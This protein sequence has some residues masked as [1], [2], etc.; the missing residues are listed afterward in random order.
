MSASGAYY[1]ENDPKAAAWLRELI[2][3]G[4]IAQ[5]EV[6]DRDIRDV[7]PADL[8]GF[9]QHHFFAG[10]GIWSYALRL[11]GWPD[12]RPVW[13]GSCPC[14]P[15]SAAG[16]G[17]GFADERHLWP[18]WHWLIQQC[19]P[20]VIFGEQVEGRDGLTWLDLVSTDLEA[21]GYACGP[22]VLPAAGVG[23]PHA[24]HRLW[25]VADTYGGNACAEREQRSWEHGLVEK[26]SSALQ[27]A[28]TSSIGW[29]RGRA[30]EASENEGQSERSCDA[31]RLDNSNSTRSQGR[32]IYAQ[33]EG[34]SSSVPSG[35]GFLGDSP[36]IAGRQRSEDLR[37]STK[38]SA[39]EPGRRHG[40]AS[41]AGPVN[42][43][44]ADAEWIYCIDNKWRPV[45]PGT[46]QMVDGIAIALGFV[47]SHRDEA[48]GAINA[49]KQIG[50]WNEVLRA[51]R[52]EYDP[53]EIWRAIGERFGIPE[54]SV[55]FALLCEYEGEL[56]HIEHCS[57]PGISKIYER[58]VREV[59]HQRSPTRPSRRR[60]LPQ[61]RSDE[62]T[63]AL[64][65]LSQESASFGAM[66]EMVRVFHGHPLAHGAPAR[67]GRIR[68]YGNGIVAQAAAE[69]IKA[70]IETERG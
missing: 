24:R 50:L 14:Q 8:A 15:F 54:A 49:A 52:N 21:T 33:G 7:T 26:D 53:Q 69:F 61:Q 41:S 59:R 23:A 25:F 55:L 29:H 60:R 65:K 31:S 64:S 3:N 19:R 1:N 11:A 4:H 45:E 13:T 66:M 42:G 39:S 44:W 70:Y 38:G 5:G 48:T 43:Y 51:L 30:S 68:G 6:D 27:L 37:G 32:P 57:T 18:A 40:G 36:S 62:F 9:T 28:D 20:G 34:S 17:A 35:I 56:G 22:V 12:D 67:M 58:A 63:D 47:R 16:K 10:I 46:Q 2:K